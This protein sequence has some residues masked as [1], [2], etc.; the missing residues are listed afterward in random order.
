MFDWEDK[1]IPELEEIISYAVSASS[2]FLKL[3][4]L[5][6]KSRSSS[7]LLRYGDITFEFIF[8]KSSISFSVSFPDDVACKIELY[9]AWTLTFHIQVSSLVLQEVLHPFLLPTHLSFGKYLP[10]F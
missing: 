2:L 6:T 8:V 10:C 4:F 9:L 5:P 1:L 7:N 3:I